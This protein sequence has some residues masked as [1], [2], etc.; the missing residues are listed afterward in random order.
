M[1]EVTVGKIW[2]DGQEYDVDWPFTLDD[3]SMREDFAVIYLDGEQVGEF[4]NPN[5]EPFTDTEQV[6][7]LAQEF[8]NMGGLD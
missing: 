8:A 3:D 5:W 4:V 7:E 6:I 2:Y 1:N